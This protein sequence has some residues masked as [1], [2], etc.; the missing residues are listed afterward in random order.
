MR[1][2]ILWNVSPV[3]NVFWSIKDSDLRSSRFP[4]L[5]T[6]AKKLRKL[7]LLLLLLLWSDVQSLRFGYCPL[8]RLECGRRL[9]GVGLG[10]LGK[11]EEESFFDAENDFY[12]P[13]LLQSCRWKLITEFDQGSGTRKESYKYAF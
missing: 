9:E 5:I 1:W 12:G 7:L 6:Q 11:L 2:K 13:M 3:K 8:L 4:H 10:L